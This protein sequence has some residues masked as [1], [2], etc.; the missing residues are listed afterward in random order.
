MIIIIIIICLR[1]VK[2]ISTKYE[3]MRCKKIKSHTKRGTYC[4]RRTQVKRRRVNKIDCNVESILYIYKVWMCQIKVKALHF[5]MYNIQVL[6]NHKRANA[7]IYNHIVVN[8]TRAHFECYF[9][10]F[11]TYW[12]SC[13]KISAILTNS[14]SLSLPKLVCISRNILAILYVR[15]SINIRIVR[16]EHAIKYAYIDSIQRVEYFYTRQ[17]KIS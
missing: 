3:W 12:H 2:P 5:Q 4:A 16:I 10:S 7:N 6:T 11:A 8:D 17:K 9:R 14:F 15:D 1:L 13:T